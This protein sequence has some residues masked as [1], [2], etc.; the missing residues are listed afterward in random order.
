MKSDLQ[1][2]MSINFITTKLNDLM[3]EAYRVMWSHGVRHLPVLKLQGD[4]FKSLSGIG[5]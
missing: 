1:N 3:A 2:S 5:I 4:I